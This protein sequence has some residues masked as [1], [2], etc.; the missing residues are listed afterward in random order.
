MQSHA[1]NNE[2]TSNS[3]KLYVNRHNIPYIFGF[4]PRQSSYFNTCKLAAAGCFQAD[5]PAAILHEIYL[6]KKAAIL[7]GT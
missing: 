5:N 3:N 4:N 2:I 6:A 1:E 7:P